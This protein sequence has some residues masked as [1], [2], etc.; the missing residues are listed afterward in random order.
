[1]SAF[2]LPDIAPDALGNPIVA[3]CRQLT[4]YIAEYTVVAQEIT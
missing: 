2:G 4:I 1:M 3:I